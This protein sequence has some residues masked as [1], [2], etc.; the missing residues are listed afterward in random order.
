MK[1]FRQQDENFSDYN[2]QI[3]AYENINRFFQ[4]FINCV[5]HFSF[6]FQITTNRHEKSV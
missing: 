1:T 6:S 5:S 3:A 4:A 2:K